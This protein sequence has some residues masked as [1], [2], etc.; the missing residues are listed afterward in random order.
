MVIWGEPFLHAHATSMPWPAD[1]PGSARMAKL[2]AEL[3]RNL[4]HMDDELLVV[5]KP[6]GLPVQSG[7]NLPVSLDRVLEAHFTSSDGHKPR[8][9]TLHARNPIKQ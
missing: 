5:N 1:A 7:T 9:G 4:L 6:P 8:W 3:R 2:A